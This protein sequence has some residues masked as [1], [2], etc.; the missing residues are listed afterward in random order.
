MHSRFMQA[1]WVWRTACVTTLKGHLN[2]IQAAFFMGMLGLGSVPGLTACTNVPTALKAPVP[3]QGQAAAAP[4]ASTSAG[5]PQVRISTWTSEQGQVHEVAIW[6]PSPSAA[7]TPQAEHLQPSID[8]V[9]VV[10]GS[11]CT[12]MAPI[13]PSYFEGLSAREIIVLHK[14]HVRASDWPRPTP[15]RPGFIAQDDLASGSRA[16]RSFMAQDMREH[17]VP[18]ARVLLMGISEGA[19]LLPGLMA[20]WPDVGLALLLGSTGLDPWEA[21]MLQLER[22]HDAS[23]AQALQ[24]RLNEGAAGTPSQSS[25]TT[26][27]AD[28]EALIGGRTLSHWRT[29]RHWPVAAPLGQSRT[30]TLVLMGGADAV[31]PPEGLLRFEKR[32]LRPGM[33]TRLV[34]GADHGLRV[35]GKQWPRLWPLVQGLMAAPTAMAFAQQ[36]VQQAE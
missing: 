28:E 25:A 17:P 6:R 3:S 27:K 34:P 8:R 36:C 19:E 35:G 12:G 24:A 5:V 13:L 26:L 22:E 31:Q 14:P 18:A 29:L 20:D 15:C 30:H 21:L 11:G 32:H 16:W 33:C 10:P 4:A 1:W 9:Y 7:H 2:N 23:F